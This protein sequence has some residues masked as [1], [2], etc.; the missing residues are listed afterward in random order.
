MLPIHNIQ[1]K[2]S[3]YLVEMDS[4]V[5]TCIIGPGFLQL[6]DTG[7]RCSVVPF[8]SSYTGV[9]D[10]KVVPSATVAKIPSEEH[11]IIIVNQG[12]WFGDHTSMRHTLFNP[13]QLI[14]YRVEVQ[15]NPF[16]K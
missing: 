7:Q 4:H 11:I 13:N 9:E 5:D 2:S 12:L 6:T 14:S 3:M 1:T 10:I 8:L 16:A 15:D